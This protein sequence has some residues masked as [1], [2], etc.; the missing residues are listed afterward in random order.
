M[1]PVVSHR[2]SSLPDSIFRSI[3][4]PLPVPDW[5]KPII[6]ALLLVALA[7]G[8]R[9]RV[10]SLRARRLEQRQRALATDLAALQSVLVPEVPSLL[11]ELEISVAYRPADGPA[12]GGDFYD[13]FELDRGRV[14]IVLGDVS[15]HGRAALARAARMRFTVRAYI[16][17]GLEPREA[18]KL[19]SRAIGASPDGLFTTVAVA[20][21]DPE[22]GS[23]TYATAGHH[24]PLTGGGR[25]HEP[26][27]SYPSPPLGWGM[28]CGRRQTTISFPRAARACFFSDGLIEARTDGG[29]LGRGALATIFEALEGEPAAAELLREVEARADE[30]RDDMAAC[31]V[32]ARGGTVSADAPVRREE[33]ELDLEQLALDHTERFLRECELSEPGIAAA[34]AKAEATASEHGVALLVIRFPERAWTVT[35]GLPALPG[36]AAAL[37]ARQPMAASSVS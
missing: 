32:T 6:L 23:L 17:A 4:L 24:G 21:H 14:A 37:D 7:F 22:T 25:S 10:S 35:P 2:G 33:L 36:L 15:G 12:A 29:L 18:L 27:S 34:L 8:V 5:S 1:P 3:P 16:E 30:I 13:V 20:I 26:L 31:I 11:G 19:A 9:A 28:P